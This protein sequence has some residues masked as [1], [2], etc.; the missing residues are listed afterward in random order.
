MP[1]ECQEGQRDGSTDKG[2]SAN[3]DNQS[4]IPRIYKGRRKDLFAVT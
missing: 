1:R 2:A 4:L 3:P